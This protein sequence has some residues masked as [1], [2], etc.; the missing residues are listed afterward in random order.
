M[1]ANIKIQRHILGKKWNAGTRM[2]VEEYKRGKNFI[3]SRKI[4][5]KSWSSGE[6]E[7]EIFCFTS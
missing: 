3:F 2:S 5:K 4:L 6:Y 7:K 1:S